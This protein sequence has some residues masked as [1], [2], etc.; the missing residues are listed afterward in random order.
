MYV[1]FSIVVFSGRIYIESGKMV[2]MNL[3]AGQQQR[4]RH[5]EQTLDTTGDRAGGQ[6]ERVAWKPI[7]YHM[8]H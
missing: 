4:R 2:T 3:S 5:R 8:Q 7:H 1:S 6:I